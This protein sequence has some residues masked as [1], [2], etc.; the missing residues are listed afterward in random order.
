MEPKFKDTKT[1]SKNLFKRL[2][3]SICNPVELACIQAARRGEAR[4]GEGPR[5]DLVRGIHF[6]EVP[7]IWVLVIF[8]KLLCKTFRKR[9]RNHRS[10]L[11]V[12]ATS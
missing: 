11:F 4:A 6:L 5:A 9:I 8:G 2:D 3:I 7:E 12:R 10:R 1:C